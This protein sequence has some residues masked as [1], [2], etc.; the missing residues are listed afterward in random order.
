M[1]SEMLYVMY[2]DVVVKWGGHNTEK[3]SVE[4]QQVGSGMFGMRSHSLIL[5]LQFLL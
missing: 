1:V 2:V 5:D 4:Q 3:S